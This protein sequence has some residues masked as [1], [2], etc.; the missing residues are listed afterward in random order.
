M[1]FSV[2]FQTLVAGLTLRQ[3]AAIVRMVP[4]LG[5]GGSVRSL[6]TGPDKVCAWATYWK[7]TG[8]SKQERF[9]E[10]LKLGLAEYRAGRLEA[11]ERA[12]EELRLGS[13]EAA[14][15]ARGLVRGLMGERDDVPQAVLSMV[16][17]LRGAEN[18]RDRVA[19]GRVLMTQGLRAAMTILDRAGVETAVQAQGGDAQKW[20]KYMERLQAV[21][22]DAPRETSAACSVP[23]AQ[24]APGNCRVG[25]EVEAAPGNC[26]G[27]SA[28]VPAP[29][30][31]RDMGEGEGDGAVADVAAEA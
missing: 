1:R 25:S 3:Q 30:N 22:E 8:W 13:V 16:G 4:V 18:D 20:A 21:E 17:I 5:N 6:L 23:C 15:L 19:A 29:V 9:Q 27:E 10:A 11:V 7:P 26:P 14:E 12:A 28:P 2:E 31:C 24:A